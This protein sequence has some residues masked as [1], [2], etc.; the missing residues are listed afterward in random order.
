M[1]LYNSNQEATLL[2]GIM[3]DGLVMLLRIVTRH[4]A[5]FRRQMKMLTGASQH[6]SALASTYIHHDSH[7]LSVSL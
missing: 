2:V 6:W 1:G 5:V 4:T 3:E 7:F